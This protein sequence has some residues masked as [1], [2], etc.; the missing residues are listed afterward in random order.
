MIQCIIS[1]T[2]GAC[3]TYK[4]EWRFGKF[5]CKIRKRELPSFGRWYTIKVHSRG[6]V[7]P[8]EKTTLKGS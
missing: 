3:K 4:T 1:Q 7:F 8:A 5:F 6:A 2:K